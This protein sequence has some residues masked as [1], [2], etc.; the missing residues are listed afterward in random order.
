MLHTGCMKSTGE[1]SLPGTPQP[2]RTAAVTPATPTALTSL[3]NP[4]HL[5]PTMSND[6]SISSDSGESGWSTPPAAKSLAHPTETREK[7]IFKRRKL[8]LSK[9]PKSTE[10]TLASIIMQRSL[11]G[12]SHGPIGASLERA[13]EF[14]SINSEKVETRM[15]KL[16]FSAKCTIALALPSD[17]DDL[18]VSTHG[19]D[20]TVKISSLSTLKVL[21]T[22][23]GHTRTPWTVVI[24]PT[25]SSI[26]ASGCLSGKVCVW[27]NFELM[28]ECTVSSEI[29]MSLAFRLDDSGREE[30][31]EILIASGVTL[32]AWKF[33][34]STSEPSSPIKLLEMS[35]RIQSIALPWPHSSKGPLIIA[36]LVESHVLR[37]T[38]K[39]SIWRKNIDVPLDWTSNIVLDDAIVYS[40][41]G[42]HISR[43]GRFMCAARCTAT[44]RMGVTAHRT[45]LVVVSLQSQNLGT[46]LRSTV[47]R[48]RRDS[49]LTSIKFSPSGDHIVCGYGVDQRAQLDNVGTKL[50]LTVF[51][52][53][54]ENGNRLESIEGSSRTSL[55][56][57]VNIALFHPVA[58]GGIL[59]GTRQ[60]PLRLLNV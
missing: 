54:A 45:E 14:L 29:V 46:I 44:P 51:R 11:A 8:I 7:G 56:D 43:C 31:D 23:N 33:H 5:T 34:R 30:E 12:N 1:M 36:E 59:Y 48:D 18:V 53:Y 55:T 58:G 24:H 19:G 52:N 21:H 40:D 10:H 49:G 37:T 47:L 13:A 6:R 28:S 15:V 22:L 17:N 25:N 2:A 60:G 20:H 35:R 41:G 38:A 4:L 39:I 50:C 3:T 27:R 9:R 42:F 26:I 32:F 57:D 16:P